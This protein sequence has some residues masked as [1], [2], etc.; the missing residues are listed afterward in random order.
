M[1]VVLSLLA[2][3]CWSVTAV[4]V[5]KG[6]SLG[7]DVIEGTFLSLA[8]NTALLAVLVL[9]FSDPVEYLGCGALAYVLFAMAGILH[10]C[11]GRTLW[12]ESINR[13]GAAT[14][15]AVSHTSPL[16]STILAVVLLGERVSLPMS[17][18]VVLVVMGAHFA[19]YGRV[20]EAKAGSIVSS[21]MLLAVLTALCWG[22]SP[23]L[24]KRG[25]AHLSPLN[26]SL[27]GLFV[28]TATF[29][30]FALSRNRHPIEALMHSFKHIHYRYFLYS[31][32][33]GGIAV[34]F[35]YTA[36]SLSPVAVVQPLVNTGPLIVVVLSYFLLGGIDKIVFQHFLGSGLVVAGGFL[37]LWR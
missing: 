29:S 8:A 1:G 11:L 23:I 16:I 10:N 24:I 9:L 30:F 21:G 17:V 26:G 27:I 15:T 32:V 5:R 20:E 33:L 34:F 3:A 2:A 13:I 36:L 14:S 6:A 22:L 28:S 37:L 4:F 19:S 31:G 18:G 12:Y 7:A 25:L 35:Q